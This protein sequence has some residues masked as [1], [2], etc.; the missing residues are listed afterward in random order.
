ME[1]LVHKATARK[2]GVLCKPLCEINTPDEL[3]CFSDN[4][5][6]VDCE[7][8]KAMALALPGGSLIEIIERASV[9]NVRLT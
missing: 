5:D 3:L 2:D 4:W 7:L 8:C 9:E 1:I 6:S